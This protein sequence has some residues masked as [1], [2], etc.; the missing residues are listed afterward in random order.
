MMGAL[1]QQPDHFLKWLQKKNITVAEGDYMPRK[2][3]R[4]YVQSLLQK[5]ILKKG[6][7]TTFERIHNEIID[8]K[9]SDN[10][11][12]LLLTPNGAIDTEMLV[13][14]LGNSAPKNPRIKN[15]AF[16]KHARYIR[17]PWDPEI[18]KNWKEQD[19]I[20]F[21]GSGQTMVDLAC[22]LYKKGY[23]GQMTTISRRGLLP[24]S[25]KKTAAYPSFFDELSSQK[26]LLP[27]LRIV[28]KHMA[29][30]L[31][32][33]GDIRSVIDSLRP[34]T[35]DIWMTLPVAEKK[36]FLRHVFRYWE[37]I[38]SRIPPESEIIINTMLKSGQMD[39]IAARIT[40]FQTEKDKIITHYRLR[41]TDS[42]KRLPVDWV[43]NC[44]GPDQDYNTID[45]P[46]IKNLIRK[47]LIHSDPAHLGINALP[48]GSVIDS[49]G[50]ISDN[51]F[52]IGITLKGIVWEALAAPEIR[53]Q[54]E[55]LADRLL[56]EN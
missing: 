19:H 26:R 41:G 48:D 24:M 1:S 18:F 35:I 55:N 38:R 8:V 32:N 37:I 10:H 7:N 36:R 14:A 53:V 51:L 45:T 49:T 22:G 6:K 21:V 30:T 34:H 16:Y 9:T 17:N 11:T 31:H 42:E 33:N 5:A 28:R 43:V 50:R 13:M 52:T 44:M 54:A 47:K 20:L 12:W 56:A 40:D 4:R 23:K 27:I 29:H 2:L 25:Q 3:Y 39:L 46:L 15:V